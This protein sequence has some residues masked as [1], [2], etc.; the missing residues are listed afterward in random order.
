MT[1]GFENG[2]AAVH[3]EETVA[4]LNN[5]KRGPGRVKIRYDIIKRDG[6]MT[7]VHHGLT[8]QQL[9]AVRAEIEKQGNKLW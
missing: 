5:H 2:Y 6:K 8:G 1:Y 3:T 9:K 4:R 7:V